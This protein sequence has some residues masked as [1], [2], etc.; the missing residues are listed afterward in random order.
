[1]APS[2]PEN[3]S[4]RPARV[5]D[6]DGELIYQTCIKKAQRSTTQ[7]SI[8]LDQLK[9]PNSGSARVGNLTF[10]APSPKR[11]NATFED[12]IK[13]PEGEVGNGKLKRGVR[14]WLIIFSLSITALLSSLEGTIVSTALPSIVDSLGDTELY[15][16]TLNGYF[17]TRY[18][19][20]YW[21]RGAVRGTNAWQ[22]GVPTTIR[23]GGRYL[24]QEEIVHR[25][26]RTHVYEHVR[27]WKLA[28]IR[29]IRYSRNARCDRYDLSKRS[30]PGMARRQSQTSRL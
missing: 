20:N 6:P 18:V 25:R 10:G 4:P 23:A 26:L 3:L 8:A 27:L 1:M 5:P 28:Y 15:T 17:L 22:H 21:I 9:G 16:W 24:W 7:Q 13:P 19:I 11:T 30:V 29:W 14:F 2:K 12:I